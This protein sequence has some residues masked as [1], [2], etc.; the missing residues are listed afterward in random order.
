VTR[1]DAPATPADGAPASISRW[2]WVVAALGLAIVVGTLAIMAAEMRV[3]ATPPDVVVRVEAPRRLTSG[4]LVPYE[5][6]N[7]GD[8]TAAAV[9][10]RATAGEDEA[11]ATL[12]Y[13]PGHSRRR[14]GFVFARPPAG[15]VTATV[16]GWAEP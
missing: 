5:A 16:T 10:L 11:T 14:G 3:A 15:P 8:E 7:R 12:D 2:E 9:A 6:E 13:V 4:W 1:P